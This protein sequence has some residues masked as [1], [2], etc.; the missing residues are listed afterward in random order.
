[1]T[2]GASDYILFGHFYGECI[3]EQCIEIFKLTNDSLYEDINDEYPN[4]DKAYDGNFKA[5]DN[6]LFE[7]IKGL[8]AQVPD[9][10]LTT[11]LRVIGQPDAGDWGGI[12]FEISS[13]EQ[14]GFWMIDKMQANLPDYLKP[15][16]TEIEKDIDL[17]EN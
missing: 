9:E 13:K 14:N 17:I 10:L 16:V 7:Q 8:Q 1:M 3:G 12:Y 5:L 6:S 2:E 4:I 15:F 11:N